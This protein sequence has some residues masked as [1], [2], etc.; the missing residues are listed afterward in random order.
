[1]RKPTATLYCPDTVWCWPRR[2]ADRV[3]L[4]RRRLPLVGR[5]WE[6]QVV[7]AS[8]AADDPPWWHH[9]LLP[10]ERPV[11]AAPDWVAYVEAA[12]ARAPLTGD[13]VGDFAGVLA[14]FTEVAAERVRERI[15]TVEAIE[16]DTVVAGFT[17]WL[18][19][20]LVRLAARTLV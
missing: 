7:G 11:T 14:P 10:G 17:E 8:R 6:S 15:G 2:G 13:G 4:C 16:V 9:A 12:L 3:N 20:R 18:G 5:A 19:R 1:M